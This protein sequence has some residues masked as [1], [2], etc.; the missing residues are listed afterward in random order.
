MASWEVGHF[1]SLGIEILEDGS[2]AELPIY[3]SITSL[4]QSTR[5]TSTCTEVYSSLRVAL[6]CVPAVS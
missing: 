6:G 2:V 4:T 3:L 1:L 5:S